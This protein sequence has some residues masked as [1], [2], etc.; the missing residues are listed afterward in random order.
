M[1][2]IH[3]IH[4]AKKRERPKIAAN[5]EGD[6]LSITLQL[7]RENPQSSL[8]AATQTARPQNGR[9][10]VLLPSISSHRPS[11]IHITKRS[12]EHP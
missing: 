6:T 11:I 2:S 3:P 10:L 12:T 7:V 1:P 9:V 8:R 4:E 5:H